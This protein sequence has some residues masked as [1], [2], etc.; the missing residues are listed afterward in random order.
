MSKISSNKIVFYNALSTI[1]LY[2]ISFFSAPIFS[3]M[4]GT[5]H[6]GV[7][8][9]Y[10]TWHSFFAIIVGL[11]TRGI[12]PMAR[13]KY[14]EEE[15]ERFQSSALGLSVVAFGV[16]CAIV[17]VFRHY[18]VPFFGLD[19][20]FLVILLLH[21]FGT[22]CVYFINAKFTYE[23]KA[24]NNMVISV[25]IALATF[26]LSLPLIKLCNPENLYAG[27]IL[28]I[29]LP[30]VIAGA[31]SL[32]YI[33]RRGKVFFCFEYWKF[34]L[35]LC[36][37]LIFHSISGMVCASSDR[38]MIQKMI[39]V[40]AVG[41]YALA[42]NFANIMNS[43]WGALNNSWTPF[44][45][46]YIKTGQYA[47]L[48]EKSMNYT[49]LFACLCIGFILLTPEV[50]HLFADAEYWEGVKIIPVVVMSH[51]VIFIYAFASNYE[52]CFMRTDFMAV[53]SVIA[54]LSNVL[55]NLV[56]INLWG[57]TGAAVATFMSNGI[58]L[59]CHVHFAKKLAGDKWVYS[60]KMFVMPILGIAVA[61][62]AFYLCYDFWLVRWILAAIT[63]VY[64]LGDIYKRKSIF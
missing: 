20:R 30:Y 59:A 42:S 17:M 38:I 62:T 32:G 34:A 5:S 40:S 47:L 24:K 55:L 21:S 57:Y 63:G 29:A 35:P 45:V 37:P 60:V 64:M 12:L 18:I 15:Q 16:V 56:F 28:G 31:L 14:T 7:V 11:M 43:I 27:R 2:A 51:F 23:M 49:R 13:V 4:L 39:S 44:M 26:G 46:D 52:F 25:V 6:Y 3:R 54:G 9:V 19:T 53:G 58:L 41:I 48:K 8:Q 50:F 36:L 61:A 10:D 33:F 1:I 22:Y